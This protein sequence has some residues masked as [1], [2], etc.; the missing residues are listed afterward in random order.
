[1]LHEGVVHIDRGMPAT[2]LAPAMVPAQT[3]VTQ[4]VLVEAAPPVL[5]TRELRK[6][7]VSTQAPV[8]HQRIDE[9]TRFQEVLPPAP[10][11][12]RNLV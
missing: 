7:V 6:E 1:V 8:L 10:V 5:E 3:L 11:V 9:R 4:P 2:T 12:Q